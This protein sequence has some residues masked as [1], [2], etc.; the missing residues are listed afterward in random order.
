MGDKLAQ[1]TEGSRNPSNTSLLTAA[2]AARESSEE[3]Y[4]V[5]S[6]GTLS[7]NP[8][9]DIKLEKAKED[10]DDPDSDWE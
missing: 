4:D 9:P 6:A 1:V 2:S 10:S 3:G 8:K 7:P 5:V